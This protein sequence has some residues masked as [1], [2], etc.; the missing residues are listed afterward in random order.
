MVSLFFH[1]FYSLGPILG[2]PKQDQSLIN[3]K[4]VIKK[5]KSARD[6]PLCVTCTH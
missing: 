6:T 5:G 2:F 3:C 1:V 4:F